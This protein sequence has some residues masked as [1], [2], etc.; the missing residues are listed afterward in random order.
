[1]SDY[2][3]IYL[4]RVTAEPSCPLCAFVWSDHIGYIYILVVNHLVLTQLGSDT[5]LDVFLSFRRC[6]ENP[7]TLHLSIWHTPIA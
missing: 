7:N 2:I 1:M 3:I 4:T 5:S 6:S